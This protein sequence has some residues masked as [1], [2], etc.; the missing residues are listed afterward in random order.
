M[1]YYLAVDLGGTK[2]SS[3]L[4]GP[5]GIISEDLRPTEACRGQEYVLGAILSGLR[6]ATETGLPA[7]CR[8]TALGVSAPGP[9]DPKSGFIYFA[10]NLKWHDVNIREILMQALDLPVWVENDAN[11]A[12]LGEQLYGSGKGCDDLVYITVSTGVGGGLILNGEIYDGSLGGAGEVGHLAVAPDGPVCSCGNCG[13]LE[14]VAS[15]WALKREARELI[16]GGGGRFLLELA[17]G[18]LEA[19]DAPLVT[20]AAG[21]GDSES[22]ALLES[23][24]SFLGLAIGNIAN[25]LNPQIF[26]IGG[27]VAVGAG[28]MLLEPA[29][30][31]ARLHIYPS[32]KENLRIVPA[33]LPGRSGLLGAA[34]YARLCQECHGG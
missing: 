4:V 34:A 33:A 1:E 8:I 7:G 24:G 11:L 18:R 5:E 30:R 19:V 6:A 3:A 17:G 28:P 27:G 21:S 10:P 32:F 31:E 13:C 12:A 14:A 22:R 26:V 23:A 25:L 15:G 16:A 29:T 2:I 9:L 20:E